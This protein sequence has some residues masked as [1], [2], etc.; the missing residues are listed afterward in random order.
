MYTDEEL[1]RFERFLNTTLCYKSEHLD[2]LAGYSEMTEKLFN[3]CL[4][5]CVK[6]NNP[7]EFCEICEQYPEFTEK[8]QK[9]E[10]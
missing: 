10:I 4:Q 7:K 3:E 9:K 8:Y 6:T 1:D 2:A 5:I